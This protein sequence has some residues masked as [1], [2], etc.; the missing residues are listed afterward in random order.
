MIAAEDW[1]RDFSEA[2]H[3]LVFNAIKPGSFDRIDYA[4]LFIDEGEN[5]PIGYI[6]LRELDQNAVYMQF[7][8]AIPKYQGNMAVYRCYQMAISF[9]KEKYEVLTT[10]IE[11]VNKSML[12]FAMREGF[13]IVGAAQIRGA[14]MLEHIMEMKGVSNG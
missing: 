12:K 6:T 5:T 14:T 2:M 1:K 4:L 9:L 3:R 13:L 11:N 7:G 10:K 8:G